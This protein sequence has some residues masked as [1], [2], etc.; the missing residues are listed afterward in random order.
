MHTRIENVLQVTPE[1]FWK[2]LFFDADFNRDLYRELGFE[3]YEVQAL[4]TLP[5]GRVRRV[6]RAEP[7]L[8]APSMIKSRLKGRVFYTEEGIY[9]PVRGVWE[10]AN[11]SSVASD[12]TRVSGSI[13]AEPH[14]EGMLHVVE[15]DIEVKAFGLGAVVERV[16]E[17]NTR[18]SYRVSTEFVNRYARERGLSSQ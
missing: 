9:D 5:D 18:D 14:P 15:L 2:H 1:V 17:K 6:L 8:N 16:I 4:E 12:S 10:F 3:A 11:E 13:R 7:P